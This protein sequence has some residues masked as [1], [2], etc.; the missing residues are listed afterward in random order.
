MIYNF[1]PEGVIFHVPLYPKGPVNRKLIKDGSAVLAVGIAAKTS[2]LF[3]VN[4]VRLKPPLA[5]SSV[6][7]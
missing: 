1:E 3:L 2:L 4:F 6:N 7:S 5:Q